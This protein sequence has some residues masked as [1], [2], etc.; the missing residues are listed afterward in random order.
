MDGRASRPP[1]PIQG[2]HLL[3]PE[4]RETLVFVE[5]EN[6]GGSG[7]VVEVYFEPDNLQCHMRDARGEAV[8][9]H[10]ITDRE[11]RQH[12]RRQP[13]NC[14][15]NCLW[16]R[17]LTIHKFLLWRFFATCGAFCQSGRFIKLRP[18][19]ART[20]DGNGFPSG[21]RLKDGSKTST[22]P[23]QKPEEMLPT[24][25]SSRK[26]GSRRYCRRDL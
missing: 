25:R 11:R 12:D 13:V 8:P 14:W 21:H 7:R 23:H 17:T 26:I 24:A 18:R 22:Q 19:P 5:L 16:G 10:K 1:T 3:T 2:T 4:T 6:R 15:E 20:S 9:E